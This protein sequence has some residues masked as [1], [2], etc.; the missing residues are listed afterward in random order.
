MAQFTFNVDGYVN[1]PPSQIGNNTLSLDN[2]EVHTFTKANFTT[3]TTPPYI[4]PEGDEPSNLKILS[5]PSEG[6]LKLNNV[7][8]QLNEIISFS[9]II[10]GL[11]TYESNGNNQAAHTP[12]F[13]FT[14]SDEGSN[15]FV[16]ENL[17]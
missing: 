14:I 11:F 6:I 8:V 17:L 9:D 7:D 10:L 3:E 5:L 1:Q 4:D 16:G 15:I 2:S 12:T 13:D